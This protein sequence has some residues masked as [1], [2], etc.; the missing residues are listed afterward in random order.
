MTDYI[1]ND[2]LFQVRKLDS[3]MAGHAG[4]IAG[5]VFKNIFLREPFKDIDIFF[6]NETDFKQA[7]DLFSK[8]EDFVQLYDNNN[9]VCFKKKNRKVRVDLVKS[10]FKEP[11]DMIK[12][13]DFTIAKFA[14]F[15]DNS[16]GGST[17]KSIY[18]PKFFEHLNLKRLVID[19]TMRFPVG[20]FERTYRYKG[21]GYG[22]CRESKAKLIQALQGA[23]TTD[24]ATDLYFGID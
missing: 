10:D 15:K 9:A 16:D 14:Y 12:S 22:M 7:L 21:Y 2:D 4:Y 13:F 17:Y 6:K 11:I 5:G 3:Y 18:H 1:E 24:L 8:N 20:T 19:D 23:N